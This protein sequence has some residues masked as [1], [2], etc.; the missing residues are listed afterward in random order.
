M[1]LK[2]TGE[3]AHCQL[4]SVRSPSLRRRECARA[5]RP[6]AA[7]CRRRA[8]PAHRRAKRPAYQPLPSSTSTVFSRRSKRVNRRSDSDLKLISVTAGARCPPPPAAVKNAS[9]SPSPQAVQPGRG[10]LPDRATSR[11]RTSAPQRRGEPPASQ[12][13]LAFRPQTRSDGQRPCQRVGGDAHLQYTASRSP[14]QRQ[15]TAR[16]DKSARSPVSS[17]SSRIS[18][19]AATRTRAL[20]V[21]SP[22]TPS[23][24]R[25]AWAC[26]A[27]AQAPSR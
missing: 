23:P 1:P 14:R 6:K 21:Y 22:G 2:V 16:E 25:T 13:R 7:A 11:R 24:P 9:Y 27:E 3:G 20:F 12:V 26:P 5:A 4:S 10:D 8:C 15:V 19:S 18:L 17:T